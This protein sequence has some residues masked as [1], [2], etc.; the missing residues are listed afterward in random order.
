M[1]RNT[2]LTA[3]L[4]AL[5]AF[6]AQ[7]DEAA[8]PAPPKLLVVISVDQ[9]SGDLFNEYR[10]HFSGGLARLQEGEPAEIGRA[11]V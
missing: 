8:R 10:A 5:C 9:F 2:W 1:V 4:L 6:T 3:A 7:G 11:H